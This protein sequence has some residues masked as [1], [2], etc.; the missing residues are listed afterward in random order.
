MER[1]LGLAIWNRLADIGVSAELRS[2]NPTIEGGTHCEVGVRV[3]GASGGH[4]RLLLD[5][6]DSFASDVRIAEA[7]PQGPLLIISTPKARPLDEI[8]KRIE[9]E[10]AD[11]S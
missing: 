10:E 7:A 8:R 6:A 5:V 9:G 4:L 1:D 3:G 11:A 2:I